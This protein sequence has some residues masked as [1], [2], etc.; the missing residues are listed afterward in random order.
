MAGLRLGMAF[1]DPK[2]VQI[3]NNIKYPYNINMVSQEQVEEALNHGIEK[4]K[5][6]EEILKQRDFLVQNLNTMNIVEKVYPT[7]S[8]FVL[9]RFTKAKVIYKKLLEHQIIVRDRTSL[10]NC[11]NCLRITVGTES[12]NLELINRLKEIEQS[13]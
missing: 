1:A 12:E 4:E 6:V 7:D 11:E 10:I 3:L 5:M 9:T 8:N 2:V 13:I